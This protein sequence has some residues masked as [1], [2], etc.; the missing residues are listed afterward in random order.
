M[1]KRAP[2]VDASDRCQASR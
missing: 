1:A 2:Y